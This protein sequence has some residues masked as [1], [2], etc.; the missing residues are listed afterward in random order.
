VF[1]RL[2]HRPNTL[3]EQILLNAPETSGEEVH[4]GDEANPAEL[5]SH[6]EGARVN[7]G[8]VHVDSFYAYDGSLTTPGCTENVRWSVLADGGHVSTA[9]V[10]RLHR[11][12]SQFANYGGYANNNRPA[13]P[14]NGR[15]VEL[16]R[17]GKRRH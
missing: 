7:H 8:H 2:G 17:G 9:A 10:S 16:R 13:Q 12:I 3:L 14:L 15:V 4:T 11:V 1:Y 6:L 5:F